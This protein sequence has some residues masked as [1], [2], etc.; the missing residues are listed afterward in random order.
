MAE[1]E[2]VVSV[3]VPVYNAEK[4]LGKCLESL[5]IQTLSNIEIIIVN[6]GS[7]DNTE[8][9]SLSY[10]SVD[11]RIKLINKENGGI[12]SARQTAVDSSTGL[13]ICS[14]DADDWI[15][16]NFCELMY[17]A[18]IQNKADVVMCDFWSEYEG[19]ESEIY[20]YGKELPDENNTII[21]E[22][23]NQQ[24]KC[25]LWNKLIKRDVFSKYNL[26]FE[27]GI[28]MGEDFL[29]TIKILQNPTKWVYIPE[30]IYHYRR[31]PKEGSYTNRLTINSYNQLIKV[32]EWVEKNLDKKSY[33]KGIYHQWVDSA[34]AGL[35]VEQGMT[36]KYY[37]KTVLDRITLS[38]FIKYKAYSLKD[39]LILNTKIFGYKFGRLIYISLYRFVYR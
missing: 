27:P 32:R 7:T 31:M 33:S 21:R 30:C 25:S 34:F 10:A 38:G 15:E 9:I 11:P 13:F 8:K 4:Y 24:I 20:Q 1:K 16:P 19:G 12:A 5:L 6:D 26:F 14:V 28:N 29:I 2:P 17:N 37:K 36:S 22:A 3:L 23:L 39:I 18:A 35:R